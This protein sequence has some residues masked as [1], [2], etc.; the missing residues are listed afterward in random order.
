MVIVNLSKTKMDKRANLII[1]AKCDQV[2]KLI[3]TELD[4]EPMVYS[5]P[6]IISK[7]DVTKITLKRKSG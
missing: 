6:S 4:L 3:M 2:M 7:S 5:G 1:N